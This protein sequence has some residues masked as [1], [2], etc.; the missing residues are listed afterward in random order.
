VSSVSLILT[1]RSL[2][3]SGPKAVGAHGSTKVLA[4][5]SLGSCLMFVS[6]AV[7]TIALAAIGRD[8]RLSPPRPAM[9]NERRAPAARG[10]DLGRRRSW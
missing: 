9:D 7:V 8:V 3:L 10:C 1:N 5:S 6:S 2:A 4:A